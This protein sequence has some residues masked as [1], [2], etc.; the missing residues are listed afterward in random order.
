MGAELTPEQRLCSRATQRV[1]KCPCRAPPAPG[2]PGGHG[3]KCTLLLSIKRG[4]CLQTVF[5]SPWPCSPGPVYLFFLPWQ[6]LMNEVCPDINTTLPLEARKKQRGH[7]AERSGNCSRSVPSP[8]DRR[9]HRHDPAV[10]AAAKQLYGAV[11]FFFFF[12]AKPVLQEGMGGREP[13]LLF[14]RIPR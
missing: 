6:S 8:V 14:P 13:E 11:F 12:P 4:L 10:P 2:D 3:D 9:G 7:R 5:A 1:D